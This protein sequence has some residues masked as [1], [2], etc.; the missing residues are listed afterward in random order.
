MTDRSVR[1]ILVIRLDAL[2]DIVLA[3]GAFEAIRRHHVE[4]H[5]T[6][7]TTK[8]YAE[9][10]RKSGWFDEVWDDGKPG[11][12]R[13]KKLFSLVRRLRRGR[14]DR[15]YDL[16]NSSR[17]M[18]YRTMMSMA[19][20]S[21]ANWSRLEASGRNGASGGAHVEMHRVEAYAR[22]LAAAG[23]E[24]LPYPDL[25]WLTAGYGGRFGLT[26]GYVLMVP[27]CAARHSSGVWPAERYAE[28]ARR[29]A[30]EGRQPVL[31]GTHE[32]VERNRIIAAA[33]PEVLN[34]T[35]K[36]SLFDLAALAA[37]ARV[38]VGHDTGPMHLIAAVGCPSVVLYPGGAAPGRTALR[39]RFV[40]IV[41]EDNLAA[42]PVTEV[43]AALRLG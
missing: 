17:T 1:R 38:A 20:G 34:L 41:R 43:A 27:G 36:A 37:H 26:N 35:N 3:F 25:S 12:S 14:F 4:A 28:L 21:R 24:E 6:L 22:Q 30:I 9:L 19:W 18:R 40:V 13:V 15:V 33:T 29:V 8:P 31:I 10:A 2:A 16:Q 23:I 42:L 5:I 11:W 32:D 39:G 7:L